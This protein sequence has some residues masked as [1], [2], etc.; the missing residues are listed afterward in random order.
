M[1]NSEVKNLLKKIYT[2]KKLEK[3]DEKLIFKLLDLEEKN[4]IEDPFKYTKLLSEI[5]KKSRK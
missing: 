5:I 1:K 2:K 4:I 3:N